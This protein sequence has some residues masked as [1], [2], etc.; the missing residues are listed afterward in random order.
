SIEVLALVVQQNFMK[1]IGA[2]HEKPEGHRGIAGN[3]VRGQLAALGSFD[4]VGNGV[5]IREFVNLRKIELDVDL[6]LPGQLFERGDPG[7]IFLGEEGIRRGLEGDLSLCA[8]VPKRLSAV[9]AAEEPGGEE[10]TV[11][12]A[13][14]THS[15][16]RVLR[17]RMRRPPAG[18]PVT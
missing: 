14:M 9:D 16:R 4:E 2:V 7:L 11:E 13:A 10:V 1:E 8:V 5:A 18:T 17:S 3:E 15:S 12:H 6:L